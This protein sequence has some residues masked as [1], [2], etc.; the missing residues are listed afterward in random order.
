MS[1]QFFLDIQ[2][3]NYLTMS[4][5]SAWLKALWNWGGSVTK[6]CSS[7]LLC[8]C[9]S[10]S[11]SFDFRKGTHK[12]YRGTIWSCNR[13]QLYGAYSIAGGY[14]K[15]Q[16]NTD[17]LAQEGVGCQSTFNVNKGDAD[18]A[19]SSIHQCEIIIFMG[20]KAIHIPSYLLLWSSPLT[21]RWKLNKIP[22]HICSV[23]QN[24]NG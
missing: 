17:D 2:K 9:I 10:R 11:I 4:C 3:R 5:Q 8:L 7:P 23:I 15:P 14:E 18:M 21:R 22:Q 6:W 16:W 13:N 12:F 19:M 1:W 24:N 20:D